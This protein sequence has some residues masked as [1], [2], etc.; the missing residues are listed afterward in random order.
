MTEYKKCIKNNPKNIFA[1]EGLAMTYALAGRYEE[2]RE[3]WSEVLKID[4]KLSVE[5]MFKVWPYGPENRERKIAALHN[6]GIK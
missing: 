4:P 5:K 6:A 2:A 1:H 3:A